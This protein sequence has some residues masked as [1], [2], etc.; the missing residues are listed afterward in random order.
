MIRES[1]NLSSRL[2]AVHDVAINGVEDISSKRFIDVGSDHGHLALY[3]LLE[4]G[5]KKAVLTDIHKDPAKRSEETMRL[6]GC[7]DKSEVYCTD[8]LDGIELMYGD[9]ICM[10]GLGGNNIIDIVDRA[11]DTCNSSTLSTVTWVLQPQKSS[12]K[13]REFLFENGFTICDEVCVEDRGIY[14]VIMKVNY[15][16]ETVSYTLSQKYFGPIVMKKALEGDDLSNTYINRL[17]D[18][19]SLARRGDEEINR[20]MEEL[21]NGQN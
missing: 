8:G 1:I 21:E 20:L 3:A 19:F 5:F 2:L 17:K 4:D 12:D 9:V 13:L 11:K 18:R 10:A 6:Y 14:Y 15:T 7:S 16:G